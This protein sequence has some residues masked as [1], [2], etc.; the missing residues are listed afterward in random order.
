M[1]TRV[2]SGRETGDGSVL[3]TFAL[4]LAPDSLLTTPDFLSAQPLIFVSER[5]GAVRACYHPHR[6]QPSAGDTGAGA[7]RNAQRQVG[8]VMEAEAL[9]RTPHFQHA[10]ARGSRE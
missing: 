5:R 9:L 8:V 3:K 2:G 10:A 1:E 4:A 6:M 7:P